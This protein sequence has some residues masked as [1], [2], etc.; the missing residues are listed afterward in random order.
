MTSR[1]RHMLVVGVVGCMLLAGCNPMQEKPTDA[2]VDYMEDF[3]L[4]GTEKDELIG[5]IHPAVYQTV[6]R[7]NVGL[8]PMSI[9]VV[10][11]EGEE[12]QVPTGRYMIT[13]YPVGNV[14]IYD[15]KKELILTEIVGSYAGSGSL[16]VDLDASYTIRVDG[17][18]ESVELTPVPT[19][20]NTES[21]TTGL[22]TVGLDI[23]AGKYEATIEGGYGYL[24][25]LEEGEEPLLYE[26]IGGTVGKS[27][28]R[29]ELK[30]GQVV[31]VTKTSNVL[32]ES[33][34]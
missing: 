8:E 34:K 21:V 30:D 3:Q 18:Y 19:I 26:L 20:L 33:I 1:I 29:V 17:G 4:S 15:E 27:M 16:T 24:M 5:T 14:F 9:P 2:A 25:I 11:K 22:W 32:L 6:N 12:V 31:R 10:P 23:E 28:S 13:G 7:D